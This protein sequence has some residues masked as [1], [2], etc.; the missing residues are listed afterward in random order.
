[1]TI[2]VTSAP[3][4]VIPSVVVMD[5]S[6]V[7][8]WTVSDVAAWVTRTGFQSYASSFT[9]LQ[10]DGDM[11]L[12]LTE[13]EIKDDIGLANGILRKRFMRELKE[14]KKNADYTSCDGGLM[15]NFLNKISPDYK[16]FTYNLILKELSLDFMQRLSAV[17][18]EDMLKDCGV[19]SAIYRHKIIEAVM[20]MDEENSILS[21]S[22]CSE[23]CTDAYI[24]YSNY[25]GAELASLIRI[26]LEMR[27]RD[28]TIFTDSHDQ[29][30]VS[31]KILSKIRDSRY[32]L[33]VLHPGGLDNVMDGHNRLQYE[34]ETALSCGA[35][36]IPVTVDFVWPAPEMLPDNIRAITSFNGVRWI[37]DYQ[38]ACIDKIE[39]FIKGETSRVSSPFNLRRDS[40]RSTPIS[41]PMMYHKA[42]KNKAISFE[43]VYS[44]QS[45]V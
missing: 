8:L 6:E 27:D 31:D 11:L 12:Q 28:M 25:G 2:P 30:V 13:A 45:I 37:H 21:D 17:D 9:E 40:G 15:A 29:N 35:K 38:D 24:S 41:S 36:I 33:L 18:L 3:R 10:V 19:D 7:P 39:K 32:Y 42:L 43:N 26:Q 4:R 23:P 44:S 34:I 16:V 1:M 5:M 20:C 14:L 22:G